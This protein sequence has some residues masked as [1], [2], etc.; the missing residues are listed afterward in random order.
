MGSGWATPA[1]LDPRPADRELWYCEVIEPN[2]WGASEIR[3][4]WWDALAGQGVV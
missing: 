3:A 4:V 1:Q 2:A